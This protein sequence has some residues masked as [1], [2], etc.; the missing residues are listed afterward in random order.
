[1]FEPEVVHV[2]SVDAVGWVS[3]SEVSWV[4]V[5]VPAPTD[6]HSNVGP[7]CCQ[8]SVVRQ[9]KSAMHACAQA[10]A[11]PPSHTYVDPYSP[12]LSLTSQ[13]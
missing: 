1:M 2:G 10:N 4:S 11:R 13:A 12:V 3:M 5:V 9:L 6:V 8:L 7:C